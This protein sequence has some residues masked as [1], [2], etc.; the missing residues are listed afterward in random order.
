MLEIM[1]AL[2]AVGGGA[3]MFQ[4]VQRLGKMKPAEPAEPAFDDDP[5]APVGAP[6]KPRTPLRSGAVALEEPEDEA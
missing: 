5:F 2:L 1:A 6:R 4:R 3:W